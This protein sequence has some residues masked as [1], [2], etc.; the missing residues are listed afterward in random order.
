MYELAVKLGDIEY[1]WNGANHVG[2]ALRYLG[3]NE[4]AIQW[5]Q[6]GLDIAERN[7]K[8]E[9]TGHSY[10]NLALL[11]KAGKNF[12]KAEQ[13]FNLAL[14]AYKKADYRHGFYTINNNRGNLFLG[15]EK[16]DEACRSYK[17]AY[18]VAIEQRDSSAIAQ[19]LNN[20]GNVFFYTGKKDSSYLYYKA[21]YSISLKKASKREIINNGTNYAY[22]LYERGDYKAAEQLYFEMLNMAAEVNDLNEKS[23]VLL[24]LAYLYYD[25]GKFKLA[26]LY[27]DS[28]DRI[29]NQVLNQENIKSL[30]TLTALY[31]NEKK[32]LR[33]S[34]LSKENEVK[35]EKLKRENTYKLAFAI[36]FILIGIFAV[37][38]FY[39]LREKEKA[40]KIIDEQKKIVEEKQGEI[41][42]SLHYAKR[43]QHTL[44]AHEDL[45]K[46][47]LNE[48]FIFYKPKDIVSG[49]FYW[50]T[51]KENKFFLAVCDSTGHGVPGAFMSLLNS[52]FLNEA[53]NE[54]NIHDPA[55]V[56]NYVRKRLIQNM[57]AEEQKDGM[58]GVLICFE[59]GSSGIVYC[60]ANSK[61]VVVSGGVLHE[62][63]C[64]KMPVGKGER[65]SDFT[66]HEMGVKKGDMIYLSTDGFADQ[67]GGEK[68]KKFK[69]KQ[70]YQLF[71]TIAGESTVGQRQIIEQKFEDW[72]AGQE[73]VDDVTVVGIRI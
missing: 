71:T 11:M 68:G 43:I 69:Y 36:G 19:T 52:S 32:E 30:N 29:D 24:Y 42:D 40:R 45:L 39:S 49:D 54:K 17:E 64:D 21:A 25:W 8:T 5:H 62:L 58:D 60:A 10:S 46:K 66:S 67:F 16:Y 57:S 56:F 70:L 26:Y 73:Q 33:I 14:E 18:K 41:L 15:Q 72:K 12:Q 23:H 13:Y 61:T 63:K 51:E 47:N 35:E 22:M 27:K 6:K 37:Y 65:T 48:H 44:L 1:Q 7:N 2:E 9:K 28:S 34:N 31:E 4:E 53:I 55:E 59:K 3:R 50:A 20:L 38:L